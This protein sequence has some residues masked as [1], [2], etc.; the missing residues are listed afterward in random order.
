[1]ILALTSCGTIFGKFE[2]TR[3]TILVSDVFELFDAIK[4][5]IIVKLMPGD[6]DI[7]EYSTA[8]ANAEIKASP[9]ISNDNYGEGISITGVENL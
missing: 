9:Y 6:Y 5:D 3:E 1:M 8:I 2:D 4:S 7:S